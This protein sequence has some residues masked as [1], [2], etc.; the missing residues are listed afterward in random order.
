[1][2]KFIPAGGVVAPA[3]V[4]VLL[5][6]IDARVFSL[7]PQK[8][9]AGY[10]QKAGA[11]A[12]IQDPVVFLAGEMQEHQ[13][14]ED[15]DDM[16]PFGIGVLAAPPVGLAGDEADVPGPEDMLPGPAG[17]TACPGDDTDRSRSA[18]AL[19]RECFVCSLVLPVPAGARISA[20]H[21]SCGPVAVTCKKPKYR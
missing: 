20:V 21:C 18:A 12:D 5:H 2:D 9:F 6:D 19:F 13:G 16:G 15:A 4:D 3:E 11:A 17:G 8:G 7:L 14:L 10:G 1:M